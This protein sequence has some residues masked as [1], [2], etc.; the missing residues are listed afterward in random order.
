[1]FLVDKIIDQNSMPQYF[2]SHLN[3]NMI[4]LSRLKLRQ[5]IFS[6]WDD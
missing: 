6:P 4:T 5:V 2:V 1:M 3:M